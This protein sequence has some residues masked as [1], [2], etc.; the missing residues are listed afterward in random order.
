MSPGRPSTLVKGEVRGPLRARICI[1]DLTYRW[2]LED[3]KGSLESWNFM[4]QAT[5]AQRYSEDYV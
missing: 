2:D 3:I 1:T 4:E 5:L